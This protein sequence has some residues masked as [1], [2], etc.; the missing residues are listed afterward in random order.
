M[1]NDDPLGIEP[2]AIIRKA[3]ESLNS[4]R[5]KAR[6]LFPIYLRHR[7]QYAAHGLTLG[8]ILLGI[9]EKT[10]KGQFKAWVEENLGCDYRHANRLVRAARKAKETV[11][12]APTEDS[13]ENNLKILC[14]DAPDEDGLPFSNATAP[15]P[16]SNTT[17]AP[18]R[19]PGQ[20]DEYQQR[21]AKK[22]EVLCPRCKRLKAP[23]CDQCRVKW[24][25][26][27][28]AKPKADQTPAAAALPKPP[29]KKPTE[30][31]QPLFLWN[32]W[33]NGFGVVVRGIDQLATIT[34]TMIVS[35]KLEG[36]RR[37]AEELR[38]EFVQVAEEMT[39]QKAPK[40]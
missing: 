16:Y 3:E 14:E 37:K 1:L 26:L 36:L 25:N 4:L 24:F 7:K 30:N 35:P 20:D 23:A 19:E 11:G 38:K 9:K 27:D 40:W 5:E 29:P 13:L 2:P 15:A 22:Q 17:Q 21:E 10:P 12:A 31:G 28:N 33:K 32:D 39:K 34:G 18:S 8:D 6:E